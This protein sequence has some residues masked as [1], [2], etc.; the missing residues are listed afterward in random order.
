MYI[1]SKLKVF[2]FLGSENDIYIFWDGGSI[3]WLVFCCYSDLIAVRV[4]L[5]VAAILYKLLL[6][7]II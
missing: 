7:F 2:D 6:K 1:W 3:F 5:A 4:F